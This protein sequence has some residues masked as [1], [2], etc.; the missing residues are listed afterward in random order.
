MQS[1]VYILLSEVD[2]Q[3]IYIGFTNNLENRLKAHANPD[4]HAYTRLYAPWKLETYVAF[5]DEKLA[6]NF[7]F[8]L[9]SHSGRAF[10]RKRLLK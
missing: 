4:S 3:K 5:K 7:E 2:N 6:K 10:L 8:Y 1:F 9:K